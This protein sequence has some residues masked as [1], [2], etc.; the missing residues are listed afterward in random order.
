MRMSTQLCLVFCWKPGNPA[1]LA[2]VIHSV[3]VLSHLGQGCLALMFPFLPKKSRVEAITRTCAFVKAPDA[4][5]FENSQ[6]DSSEPEARAVV[7]D[8]SQTP[9]EEPSVSVYFSCVSSAGKL[10]AAAED[11]FQK[12]QEDSPQPE[13]RVVVPDHSQTPGEEP[14]VSEYFS[15]VSS[16]G[17]LPAATED[18]GGGGIPQWHQDIR[19]TEPHEVTQPQVLEE[20]EAPSLSTEDSFPP[21]LGRARVKKIYY[22]RVQMKRGV[23]VL[24]DEVE[25]YEPASKKTK[26][27]FTFSEEAEKKGEEASD[28]WNGLSTRELVDVSDDSEDPQEREQAGSAVQPPAQ[29]ETEQAGSAVQPPAQEE[30]EQAGS[31]VQ[32]PAQEET[33]QA[34]SAVQPPAQEETEQA[35]SAVEPPAQEESPRAET[36]EWLVALDSGFR[37]LGCCRVFPSLEVLQEHVDNAV[38]EGFSCHVFQHALAWLNKNKKEEDKEEEK[39]EEEEDQ[40][41]TIY[42]PKNTLAGRYPPAS[43]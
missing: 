1:S 43:M 6:E 18:G 27:Q 15:C 4:Q 40:R 14:S 34:G 16:P 36:P 7:P 29:E 9:G 2:F 41:K 25:V 24:W 38:R 33:E 35:G 32:P 30:T 28:I 31:A 11:E 39:E 12:S 19:R 22:R 20:Q 10:P 23:A 37:C 26:R 21:Y 42:T 3:L 17:K 13:A 8:R 5:E